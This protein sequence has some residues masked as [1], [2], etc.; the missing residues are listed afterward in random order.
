MNAAATIITNDYIHYALAL[1]ESFIQF[2]NE[3]K[4]YILI[5]EEDREL[6]EK[7]EKEYPDT[8]I[9]FPGDLCRDGIA[10]KI[11]D[12]Y[13]E[14]F[15]HEFRW[16]MKPVL[17]KYL[18][19]NLNFDKALYLDWDL[20]FFNAYNFLF[21]KLDTSDVILTPHW[22][23]ANPHADAEHFDA[24]F[25]HGLFNAGFIGVNKF[26]S[27]PLAWWAMAC[28]YICVKNAEKGFYDDQAH[29]N[30]FPIL[31]DKVEIL[32][33]RGCN[34][35][36]W[37]LIECR[38]T[39]SPEGEVLINNQYPIVFIHFTPNTIKKIINGSDPL[40]ENHLNIYA[41]TVLKYNNDCDI[42]A[43]YSIP[44]SDTAAGTLQPSMI[45]RLLKRIT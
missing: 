35:A 23:S 10:R 32:K 4:F 38:R 40:L 8:V 36:E 1:R 20:F 16:S 25:N 11:Y 42:I 43:V 13:F 41:Q 14:N 45:S 27:E 29:L 26:A 3:I 15:R 22:R 37:N 44:D 18:I 2:N 28:E 12:K 5:T 19:E 6:K 34:V 24:L 9:L 7:I 21:E 39:K 33:H 30:L 17:L 31:S